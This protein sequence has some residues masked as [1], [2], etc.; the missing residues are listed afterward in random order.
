LSKKGDSARIKAIRG[1]KDILPD[2]IG[3]WRRVESIFRRV[4][5]NYGFGEIR[6]PIFEETIL[7]EKGIGEDTDIVE[8]EMYTFDDRGGKSITLRPEGTAPAVRAFLEHGLQHKTPPVKLYYIGPMFRHERPQKGRLRQFYQVGAEIFGLPGPEA[9]AELLEMLM[10]IL[11][12]RLGL[13]ALELEINTLGDEEC[14]PA[15]R[16]ALLVYLRG[17]KD[18]LCED[19]R[20]R[21]ETNP[22]RILDCKEAQC[23]KTASAAPGIFDFLCS[24]CRE[25]FGEVCRLLDDYDVDYRV[26]HQMVRGLDY[27]TRTTYEIISPGLGA[28]NAVAAGGRY[29]NLVAMFGGPPTPGLGWALGLERLLSLS[30]DGGD[31]AR[32]AMIYVAALDE[33]GRVETRRVVRDLRSRGITTGLDYQKKSLKAQM[34]QADR[35]GSDLV[36]FLGGHELSSGRARIKEMA[37]GR[38]EEVAMEKLEE[39]LIRIINGRP[40]LED[41][42]P[43]RE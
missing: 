17:Q 27:Y 43:E 29:D 28:Q 23:R 10:F 30:L 14:R 8:K 5:D 40:D 3:H 4:L 11:Q 13:E 39:E 18:K 25:H 20:R 9:E 42:L 31:H 34:R 32:P 7:F 22:L 2:D 16:T 19:C 35:Q 12:D 37:S 6:L 36:I 15:Y 33:E 1:V 24:E 26:N 41:P 21:L 38:E